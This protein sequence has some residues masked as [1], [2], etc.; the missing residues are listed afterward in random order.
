MNK[1]VLASVAI[2]GINFGI[3]AQTLQDA[4]KKTDNER[5]EAADAD[6]KALIAKEPARGDYYY[7]YGENFFQND[8]PDSALIMFQKGTEV[9]AMYPPNFVGIGKVYLFNGKESEANTN[10]FK[11][12]TLADDKTNKAHKALTYMKI[13]EAYTKAPM[14]KNL[15]EAIKLLTEATKLESKNP[16]VYILMGDALLEQNPTEGGAPIKQYDKAFELDKKSVKAILRKGKLYERGRNYTEAL[17]Y[18]KDAE[19][20]DA[21]FAPAYREKG[22]IY[23]KAARFTEAIEAYKKYLEL[24]DSPKARVRYIY[25]LFQAKQY[26]NAVTEIDQLLQK[27]P[28]N[29][30]APYMYRILGYSYYEL[31]DKT[32]K[33]AYKKGAD[34]IIKFFN[35]TEGK[36]FKYIPDDY[37]YKGLLLSKTAQDS[38]GVI[39]LEKAINLDPVANCELWGDIG[40]IWV[41]LKRYDK[42]IAAYD[43]KSKCTKG[44]TGQDQYD[45]GRAYFY[46]PKDFVKADTAFSKL[47]QASPNYAIGYF[48]R[49]KANVQQ[50]PKNDKW[51]AKPYYE[52]G[53]ELVKPEERSTASYKAN[54]IEASEYLGYYYLVKKDN[55]KAKEYFNMIKELDPNNQKAKDFFKSP[56]GK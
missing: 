21:T 11:A 39:E 55:A 38:L 50:D 23:M 46:G 41:K 12:K 35:N 14:Y 26:Q 48:W 40:K 4:I 15:P 32:D 42:A 36:N 5:Y 19:A 6:F 30:S 17:K 33:E 37:K 56:A 34:A 53:L 27:E 16:E 45:L 43:N 20:V 9:N 44:L 47:T 1:F 49:A 54:V 29:P 13:A 18:Y 52:K 51:L 3:G 28:N 24:N 10:I 22:E 7:Y 2:V 31:T 25:A 8:N